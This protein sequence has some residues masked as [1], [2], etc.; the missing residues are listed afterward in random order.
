[1]LSEDLPDAVQGLLLLIKVFYLGQLAEL[2]QRKFLDGILVGPP[3]FDLFLKELRKSESR[4]VMQLNP[5][6]LA[7]MINVSIL[8]R[9]HNEAQTLATLGH[10]GRSPDPVNVLFD[11]G[12][13][14]KMHN[15]CDPFKV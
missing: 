12:A 1:M 13:K 14:I 2:N 11:L 9:R 8:A 5:V 3:L 6:L 10:P 4:L 15:P 7:H